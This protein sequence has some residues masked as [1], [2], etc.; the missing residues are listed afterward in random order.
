MY[1]AD[2]FNH[3]IRKVT[4]SASIISTVAGTGSADYS[5]DNGPAASASLYSPSGVAVD[6]TG[7][8]TYNSVCDFSFI[9]FMQATSIS[10][11]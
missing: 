4:A 2:N 10:L 3:S 9:L 5:G 11:I 1:I 7:K 8:R 6:A